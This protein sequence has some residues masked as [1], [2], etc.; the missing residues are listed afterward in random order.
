MTFELIKPEASKQHPE[1]PRAGRPE[2]AGDRDN[3]GVEAHGDG[4][5]GAVTSP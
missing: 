5:G 3:F 4:T 1:A 2:L